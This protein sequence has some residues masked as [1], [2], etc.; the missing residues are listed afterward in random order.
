MLDRSHGGSAEW[1]RD[2]VDRERE[3]DWRRGR[4]CGGDFE[5]AVGEY[6]IP[7]SMRAS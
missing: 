4:G 5:V 7:A 1:V 2:W 3:G 6:P